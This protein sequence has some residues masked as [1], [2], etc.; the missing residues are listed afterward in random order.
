MNTPIYTHPSAPSDQVTVGSDLITFRLTSAQTEGQMAVFDLSLPPGGGA[1]WLHRHDPFELYH[2]RQGELVIY[3]EGKDGAIA[4]TV[5][6]P[7]AVVA[8]GGG[9][10]HTVRNESG[11]GAEANV[12]FCPGELMERF[13]RAAGALG[14]DRPPGEQE[15]FALA[16][17]HGIEMTRSIE[18]A[19][20]HQAEQERDPMPAS[21]AAYLTI[22]QFPGDGEQLLHEYRR[23]S[24]VMSEVG[25][26]HGLILHAGAKT[27]QG[28]MIV[29]LWPTQEHSQAAAHDPRRL[30]VIERA[31]IPT[32]Q[33]RHQH[34]KVAHFVVFNSLP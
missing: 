6:G 28:F 2:V 19:P 17:A 30:G 15:L 18:E 11:Q 22:A 20:K 14:R 16:Q 24:D 27:D 34:H 10:E 8:I 12:V 13:A 3:L 29:N 9:L 31:K 1:A 25:R 26:D 21:G 5:A 33:I 7:G 4:R 23:Y 32:D